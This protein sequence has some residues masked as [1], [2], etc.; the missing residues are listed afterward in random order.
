MLSATWYERLAMLTVAAAAA[1]GCRYNAAGNEVDI[2]SN[3]SSRGIFDNRTRHIYH[4]VTCPKVIILMSF[5]N[6]VHQCA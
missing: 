4:A 5:C 2:E 1:S 3:S 6:S